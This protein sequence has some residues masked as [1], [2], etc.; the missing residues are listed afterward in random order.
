M[1]SAGILPLVI[2]REQTKVGTVKVLTY[3]LDDWG[4]FYG[5]IGPEPEEAL[6][7][8]LEH[9][10]NSPWQWSVIELRWAG[11]PGTDPEQTEE[12]MRN[13]G[14]QAYRTLR[15]RTS[16]IELSGRWEE[17]MVGRKAKWRNNLRRWVKQRAELQEAAM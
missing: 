8:G 12:A 4:S 1:R 3:P 6:Q 9:I 2:R 16:L 13:N 5:P 7:E 15:G 10:R 17:Y 14:F 11:A